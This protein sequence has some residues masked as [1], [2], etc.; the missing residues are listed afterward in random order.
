[1]LLTGLVLLLV[2]AAFAQG[3]D[4]HTLYNRDTWVGLLAAL[5]A[6]VTV[7]NPWA[8]AL[9]VLFFL[10][11]SNIIWRVQPPGLPPGVSGPFPSHIWKETMLPTVPVVL[12]YVAV[13]P[14]ASRAWIEPLLCVCVGLGT[15][16]GLWAW[17]SIKQPR[18]LYQTPIFGGRYCLFDWV[19]PGKLCQ[20]GQD[21]PNFAET[22]GVVGLAACAGLV[23]LGQPWALLYVPVC[24]IPIGVCGSGV[25]Q[26]LLHVLVL[27]G[28]MI[29]LA[30]YGWLAG[31]GVLGG[32]GA[33]YWY[34]TRKIA[35][36]HHVW[37]SQRLWL[38]GN[39]MHGWWSLGWPMRLF[40]L[41]TG[42]F[43]PFA[44]PLRHP[45][46]PDTA[47]TSLHNEYLQWVV[48]HGLIGGVLLLGFLA[49]ASWR[50]IASG[51]DGQAVWLMGLVLMSAASV[52]FPWTMVHELKVTVPGVPDSPEAWMMH[53]D[54]KLEAASKG[55][56]AVVQA[57]VLWP[58]VFETV[59]GA[60]HQQ[61]IRK[62]PEFVGSPTLVAVS[63]VVAILMEAF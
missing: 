10:S 33:A 38:W 40:G 55:K 35:G 56:K 26:G 44:F 17:Y 50:L 13:S 43:R 63:V 62:E 15:M 16:T 60:F 48:E 59:K 4:K 52:G 28:G 21:M 9:L 36:G 2:L 14:L 22:I 12:L 1:M 19:L 24:A 53:L 30:G 5:G 18:G 11:F 23:G 47:F 7:P 29:L 34:A 3:L 37:D 46:C 42:R 31:L 8:A 20:A 27:V 32:I 39:V 54:Q 51:P 6:A 58:A 49:D 45:T 61:H 25:T 57:E 41:G